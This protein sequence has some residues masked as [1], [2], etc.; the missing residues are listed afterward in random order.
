VRRQEEI[1]SRLVEI[2]R[3]LRSEEGCPW[4]RAQNAESLAQCVLSEA[5]ELREAVSAR[6]NDA[7]GEEMGDVLFTLLSMAVLAEE[8][9]SFS[10]VELLEQLAAKMVRRHPHVFGTASA[11]TVQEALQCWNE[12]KKSEKPDGPTS[13]RSKG[14]N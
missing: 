6:D 8:Q 13:R 11:K 4:D 3:I 10:L 14:A 7:I 1:F 5:Q 2:A 9:G 12:A